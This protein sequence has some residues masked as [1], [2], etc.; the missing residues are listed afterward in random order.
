[1]RDDDHYHR[2]PEMDPSPDRPATARTRARMASMG[3]LALLMVGTS[4]VVA[5]WVSAWLVP[6]YL[7]L[8]ALILL[9]SAGRPLGDPVGDE[10]DSD[11]EEASEPARP[12]EGSDDRSPPEASPASAG[13]VRLSWM[14]RR[15]VRPPPRGVAARGRRGR[16]GPS[17]SPSRRPGSKCRPGSS[18]GPRRPVRRP[19]PVPTVPWGSRSRPRPHRNRRKPKRRTPPIG[20]RPRSRRR[21]QRAP[22]SP[23]KPGF[24]SMSSASTESR[25]RTSCRPSTPSKSREGDPIG[26]VIRSRVAGGTGVRTKGPRRPGSDE[27]LSAADGNAPAGPKGRST[28]PRRIA[29]KPTSIRPTTGHGSEREAR[30]RSRST[31]RPRTVSP[32]ACRR[33]RR[34][35]PTPKRSRRPGRKRPS[36]SPPTRSTTRRD[37]REAKGPRPPG[38]PTSRIASMIP[39]VP[40]SPP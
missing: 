5:S 10:V 19:R 40:P 16:R 32:R 35:R 39:S 27:E 38:P 24:R 6:P 12:V 28:N 34:V 36:P 26:G 15:Y 31:R 30:D 8:M 23:R 21:R 11:P 17:P 14:G 3:V 22:S 9:P 7:I 1:M 29:P 37:G 20:P 18:S 33:S 4:W 13:G 2:D 25:S